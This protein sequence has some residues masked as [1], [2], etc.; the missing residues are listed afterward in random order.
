MIALLLRIPPKLVSV[1]DLDL[2]A[3]EVEQLL[4]PAVPSLRPF[5][6]TLLERAQCALERAR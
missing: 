1:G 5:A 4:V 2:V 6:F 3:H